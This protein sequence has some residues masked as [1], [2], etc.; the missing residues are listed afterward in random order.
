[1]KTFLSYLLEL[2]LVS[3]VFCFAFYFI[4]KRSTP[5]F[6][7]YFLLASVLFSIAFPFI[8]IDSPAS[9]PIQLE[10]VVTSNSPVLSELEDYGG[11]QEFSYVETDSSRQGSFQVQTQQES[12]DLAKMLMA[13]Y[14]AVTVFL[15]LRILVGIIQILKL[16]RTALIKVSD[17]GH[18]YL[19]EKS[20]FR[21]ASFFNWVFIGNGV[22]ENMETILQHEMIHVKRKH[23]FDILLSHLF[24]ALF[25]INPFSWIVRR[26]IRINTELETDFILTKQQDRSGYMDM[27]LN[28]SQRSKGS[29]VLNHFSARHLKIRIQEM[30]EPVN[31]RKWVSALFVVLTLGSFYLVSCE[32]IS[33]EAAVISEDQLNEVKSITTRFISHQE[34]TQQKTDKIVSIATFLPD[35]KLDEFTTQTTYPY[36]NEFEDK[37]EFWDEPIRGNLFYIMDGLTMGRAEKNLLYGNDWTKAY[38]KYLRKIENSEV[39]GS[40]PVEERFIIDDESKPNEILRER[41][42]SEAMFLFGGYDVK[43]F[44]VYDGDKVIETAHMNVYK[45]ID[46]NDSSLI[47]TIR[48]NNKD[49]S[50]KEF[51]K[52]R[53]VGDGERITDTVYGYDG[54]LLSSMKYKDSF[55]SYEYKFFYENDV[56]IKSEYLKDNEI[57]S[58]RFHYYKD[59]LKDRT[60]I[61]NRYNEAEYTITY[62]YEY[63]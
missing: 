24:T 53:K 28:L 55:G 49:V 4:R 23:S 8:T 60:E 62:S 12:F 27:L 63:W 17:L 30:L 2:T 7:R 48:Y 43:E 13:I 20:K 34:D 22:E 14:G 10:D 5:F 47:K 50:I 58:T 39:K 6:K 37:K 44:F 41:I 54:E 36:D 42:G 15:L 26:E 21:G 3:G 56:L 52:D 38:V 35:G 33:S 9:P 31:Q 32:N 18:Y 46:E 29:M 1:M 25:W 59:G 11:Q 61:F 51:I 40:Y 16:R 57:I 19:I 45:E